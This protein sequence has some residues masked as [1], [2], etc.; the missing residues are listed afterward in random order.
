MDR[1]TFMRDIFS[2]H[3]ADVR[4]KKYGFEQYD[5]N[6]C[7]YIS[8]NIPNGENILEVAIG[9]GFPF[10]DFFQ[11]KGYKVHGVDIA[12][13]L[14]EKCKKLNNKINCKVGDAENLEY[15]DNFFNCTYCFRST[16]Y[17]TDICKVID[18]MIRVTIPKGMIIFDISN[19][20]NKECI[21]EFNR[22][23]LSKSN[24]FRKLLIYAKNILKIILRKGVPDWTNVVYQ[25]P[26]Y[27]ETIYQHF[28][29][30]NVKNYSVMQNSNEN[31]SLE[32]KN[33]IGSLKNY[34][35]LVFAIWKK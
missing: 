35:R 32:I 31:D 9:T 33:E 26:I 6:L 20:N 29:K 11:K 3:W 30:I 15:P 14:I 4:E 2:K 12:P 5:K 19:R 25:V 21:Q 34:S 16:T 23:R 28:K 17:F 7:N 10:G 22:I 13:I 8:K 24:V 1:K 18:E 27:P